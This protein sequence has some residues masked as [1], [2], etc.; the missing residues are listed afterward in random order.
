LFLRHLLDGLKA[1]GAATDASTASGE[2]F[3]SAVDN[4]RADAVIW[5]PA[6]SARG[7]AIDV[8]IWSGLT[9]PRLAHSATTADWVTLAAE[10]QKTDK[11]RH[12]CDQLGLD[13]EP[14]AADPASGFGPNLRR[15]WRVCWDHRLAAA[16]AA[17][18]PT[19]PIASQ[20]RRCLERLSAAL[21][22]CLHRGIATRLFAPLATTPAQP[23]LTWTPSGLLWWACLFPGE[24]DA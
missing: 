7:I 22:R 21:I 19:R 2:V 16:T 20:E 3:I 1:A 6:L 15:V 5:H 23:P 14:L 13:F 18:R 11:Y 12:L 24:F 8:T 17:G 10:K 4:K 9:L